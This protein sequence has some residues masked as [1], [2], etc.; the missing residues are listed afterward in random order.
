MGIQIAII[1][2]M[3]FLAALAMFRFGQSFRARRT[4]VQKVE[5]PVDIEPAQTIEQFV[6]VDAR[7][8]DAATRTVYNTVVRGAD[9]AEIRR[10]YGGLGRQWLMDG[11]WRFAFVK[12]ENGTYRPVRVPM[13]LDN[14]PSKLYR[15]LQQHEIALV[16]GLEQTEGVFQKWGPIIWIGAIG[17]IALFI[18]IGAQLG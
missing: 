5:R 15:A 7:V 16:F 2:G 14:P 10:N 4:A 13:T 18:L 11:Q 12:L 3:L 8:Y 9:V 17:A 6:A 1:V